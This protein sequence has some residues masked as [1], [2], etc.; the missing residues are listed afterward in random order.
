MLITGTI[1]AV[2]HSRYNKYH[3]MSGNPSPLN[4]RLCNN[5]DNRSY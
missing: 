5:S 2:L 3:D 4:T 1:P